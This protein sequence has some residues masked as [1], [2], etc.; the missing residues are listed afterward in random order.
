M[1]SL[2]ESSASGPHKAMTEVLNGAVVSSEVGP[3]KVLGFQAQQNS[4]PF[5]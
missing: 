4:V 3:G 1:K 5:S 2:A